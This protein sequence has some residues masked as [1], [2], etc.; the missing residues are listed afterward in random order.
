MRFRKL[1]IAWSVGWGVAAGLLIVLWVRSLVL[2]D[3]LGYYYSDSREL[4]CR[5][6][7]GRLEFHWGFNPFGEMHLEGGFS[8]RTISKRYTEPII[9]RS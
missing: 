6:I 5:S 9:L 3:Y 7:L 1:R 4:S 2:N 8:I